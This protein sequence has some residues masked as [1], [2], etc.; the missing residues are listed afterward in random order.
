M[1]A[2]PIIAQVGESGMAGGK[3]P[4]MLYSSSTLG[5]CRFPDSGYLLNHAAIPP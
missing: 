3:R 5:T 2:Q 4:I 1:S